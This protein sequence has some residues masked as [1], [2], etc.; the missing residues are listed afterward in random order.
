MQALVSKALTFLRHADVHGF[1]PDVCWEWIGA[2]KGNGYGNWNDEGETKP[3]HRA[4]YE[5]FVGPIPPELDVCHSCDN[6]PCINPH[7]L[8]PGT[9]LEN[10][11]DAKRKSR[12][13]HGIRVP[14]SKLSEAQVM[15]AVSR[16]RAGHRTKA[17]AVD[18]GVCAATI[19]QIKIGNTWSHLTGIGVQS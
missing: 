10:M 15:Q 11:Q 17:I 6:R 4:S 5:L 12:T 7:H 19:R 8:F 1:D 9:R 2:D 16:L 13:S 18:Y 14:G 3:A